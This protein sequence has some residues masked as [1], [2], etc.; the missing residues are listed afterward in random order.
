[1]EKIQ[2]SFILEVLGRP[3][4]HI[5][6]ALNELAKR[7]ESEKGVKIIEKTFHEPISV[8]DS[9]DLFTTFG[10]FL[11]E[12][13]SLDNYF[14]IIFAYMPANIEI[15]R[16]EKINLSNQDINGL[17]YRIIHRLHDYDAITKK[18]LA[19]NEILTKKLHEVAPHLFK[20]QKS[21]LHIE[22]NKKEIPKN[23]ARK[24]SRKK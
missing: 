11:V 20:N 13:D 15:I 7:I 17:A 9:W 3:K 16:P 24:K 8:Q 6:Q 4:E 2:A 5:T 23:K 1:M 21:N 22:E 14:G 19:E 12:F 18:A 10:E